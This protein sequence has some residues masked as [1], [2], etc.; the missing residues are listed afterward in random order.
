[1]V[2]SGM[3]LREVDKYNPEPVAI[4]IISQFRGTIKVDFPSNL[5][6]YKDQRRS[7]FINFT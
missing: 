6:L 2:G 7:C 1:M 4:N 5:S 3:T